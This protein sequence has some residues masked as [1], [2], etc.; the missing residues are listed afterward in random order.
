MALV[1]WLILA[2][3]FTTILP[4]PGLQ[5]VS[6]SELR[7][8]VVFYPLVGFGLGA[9]LWG[10]QFVFV[11]LLGVSAATIFSLAVYTLL[12]G[13][14]HLDGLMDTMDALGSHRS[15][16]RALEIM[17]DSRVGAMGAIA[18]ILLLAGKG[19]AIAAISSHEG[20][21]FI[22]VPGLSRLGMVWSMKLA[23]Y[24]R[25]NSG[26]GQIYAQKIPLWTEL[27]ASV[28]AGIVLLLTFSWRGLTVLVPAFVFVWLYTAFI[29]HRFGGMTGDTYGALNELLEWLGWLFLPLLVQI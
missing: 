7:Q 17:R 25:E 1:R 29:K 6:E 16:E 5:N 24:A 28:L 8:S 3:Q 19:T 15:R 12:T 21:L 11:P 27:L 9:V 4:T 20:W 23:P 22:L 13:G 10:M 18:G 2:L 14:L 26:V